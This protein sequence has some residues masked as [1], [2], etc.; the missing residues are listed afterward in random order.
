MP[1]QLYRRCPDR[2]ESQSGASCPTCGG[3]RYI[4]A[5][6]DEKG[7]RRWRIRIGTLML[8]VLIAA[9]CRSS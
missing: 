8:L 5:R 3:E 4:P 9:R 2:R 1:D 6:L 7:R